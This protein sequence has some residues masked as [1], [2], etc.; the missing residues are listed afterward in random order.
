M[1]FSSEPVCENRNCDSV[2]ALILCSS[3]YRCS[4][5]RSCTSAGAR[6]PPASSRPGR[7]REF[8]HVRCESQTLADGFL[9]GTARGCLSLPGR[10]AEHLVACSEY[11]FLD[12]VISWC[13][14]PFKGFPLTSTVALRV[15]IPG[16]A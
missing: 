15:G 2:M 13:L 14:L 11:Q 5:L 7:N 10:P 12:F 3:P 16:R 1:L 6:A 8:R 9:S 4:A